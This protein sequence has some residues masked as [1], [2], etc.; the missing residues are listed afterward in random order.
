MDFVR[1]FRFERMGAFVYSEED[2][3]PA[4]DFPDQVAPKVRQRRRDELMSIQQGISEAWAEGLVGREVEV[5]VEGYNEDGW[6][7]GRTQWDAPDVDPL[8]FLA[9]P[10][11]GSG[12]APLEAGQIR[13]CRVTGT[14]LFDLEATPV[15]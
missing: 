3:T 9:E 7:M 5:L 8:V 6:L 13:V 4:A 10:E 1:S 11:E 2:G 12:I 15:A 14:S